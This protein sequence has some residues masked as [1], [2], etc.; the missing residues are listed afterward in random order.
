MDLSNAIQT[1]FH[2]ALTMLERAVDACPDTLW[3]DATYTNR[4]W[5]IAYHAL[6]YVHLYLQKSEETFVPWAKQRPEYQFMGSVPWPPH[7]PPAIDEAYSQADI[8]EYIAVLREQIDSVI[9]TLDLASPS[10]G[11]YWLP[12]SKLELQFYNLRHLQ[13][14]TGELCERLDTAAGIAIDWVGQ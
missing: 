4:F 14:H 12:F 1:Q 9:P 11:F 8:R 7:E 3:D 10:S 2:A 5:H 6:F 13:S